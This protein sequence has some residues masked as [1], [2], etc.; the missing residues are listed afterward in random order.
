M[1]QYPPQIMRDLM[2]NRN[3]EENYILETRKQKHIKA[4]L[5]VLT[6]EKLWYMALTNII[7][8][9]ISLNDNTK[10]AIR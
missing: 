10:S 1:F 6:L 5:Y 9:T 3:E 4:T 2:L 8:K 7:F